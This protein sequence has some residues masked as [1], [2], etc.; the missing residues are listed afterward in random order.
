MTM[1]YQ[2]ANHHCHL[3]KCIFM[4]LIWHNECKYYD[5]E[6]CYICNMLLV[7]LPKLDV[8]QHPL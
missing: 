1:N 7:F 4:L 8:E 2:L 5:Y 6:S 3:Y